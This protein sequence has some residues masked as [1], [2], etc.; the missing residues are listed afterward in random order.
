VREPGRLVQMRD[1]RTGLRFQAPLN[2]TKRIRSYPGI[3]RIASGGADVSGWAYVRAEPLPRTRSQLAAA[4]DALVRQARARN[5]T[6]RLT[7][8]RL[9]RI[10]GSPA[11][12]LSGTQTILG[13]TIRTRSLHIFR[14]GE[15]V[16]EA[17]AP[18]RDFAVTDRKVLAPLVHS[19]QFRTAPPA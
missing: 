5:A 10:Q 15:Y 19:L 2:W 13:K 17:L 1:P 7:S 16:L 8:S 18:P 9:T 11:I 6:F 3:F 4:R 14:D 12:E